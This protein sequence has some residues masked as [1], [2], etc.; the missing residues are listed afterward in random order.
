[1]VNI[2][3]NSSILVLSQLRSDG[4]LATLATSTENILNLR[5]IFLITYLRMS[6]ELRWVYLRH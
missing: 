4:A 1:M 2:F 5:N 3:D 6:D